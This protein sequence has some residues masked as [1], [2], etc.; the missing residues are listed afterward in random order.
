MFWLCL[1][2]GAAGHTYGANGI[3]QCNRPGEPHGP[4]PHHN[5]GVGYGK[6]P[7]N[8]A[9]NLPG[10]TQMGLGKKFFERFEWWKFVPQLNWAR[11]DG[12]DEA[13]PPEHGKWIWFPEG[14]PRTDAPAAKRYFRGNFVLKERDA[15][16]PG[17]LWISSDDRCTIYVNGQKIADHKGTGTN[18]SLIVESKL[19]PGSNV[20]AVEAENLPAPVAANPAG[21]I[22]SLRI[23]AADH[24]DYLIETN[25][26]WR[27]AKQVS[28][29]KT[30]TTTEF[31]DR[32]WEHVKVLGDYGCQPWGTFGADS[33]GP[34]TT[35]V[36]GKLWII[37]SPLPKNVRMGVVD[38]SQTYRASAF[39]P[40]TGE[41]HEIG[42]VDPSKT[43][44]LVV[45]R[46]SAITSDDWIVVL[47]RQ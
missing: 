26:A 1:T 18:L 16:Q 10:S 36:P 5:G 37:Y 13:L 43:E 22:A 12:D 25:D 19:K 32:N 30:W 14:E 41:S 2:N 4:S 23:K 33:Y 27:C 35:G 8:E 28:D 38:D 24:G 21:L 40:T 11:Y 31:D 39:D 46:P 29:N 45:R 3:W 9:M 6:I 20:L 42:I 15:K 34:Y 7:W 44:R 47:E 17:R